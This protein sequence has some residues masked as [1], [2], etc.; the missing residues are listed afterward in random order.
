MGD[1]ETLLIM[2]FI[3]FGWIPIYAIRL[4][5]VTIVEAKTTMKLKLR[6]IQCEHFITFEEINRLD[7]EGF[8]IETI[9]SATCDKC[10]QHKSYSKFDD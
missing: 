4:L 8:I 7:D 5:V 1:N 10:G 2:M 3:F 9:V 6:P